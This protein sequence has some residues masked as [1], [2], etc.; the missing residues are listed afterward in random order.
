MRTYLLLALLLLAACG[1]ATSRPDQSPTG[2][3]TSVPVAPTNAASVAPTDAPPAAPAPTAADAPTAAPAAPGNEAAD[4]AALTFELEPVVEGFTRPV[5]VTAANDGSN[6]LF[7]TEQ[8]GAIWVVRDGQRLDEP[9]LDIRALVNAN[10]NEQGLLSIAFHPQYAENGRFFVGY[11][12]RNGDNTVAAYRVSDNPDRADHESGQVLLAVPDPAPNHNGGLVKFGPDGYLYIGMGDGGAAGDPWDNG[13]SLN[14]LLGKMLRI[15]VDNGEP[16]AIPDDNPF[17]NEANTQ[18][19]IWAWGLRNPWRF[20]F[21]RATGD[22]YIAD[23][24]QNEYEEVHFQPGTSAGGEN[25]GWNTV[26][27]DACFRAETCDTSGF[28][29]PVATYAHADQ[30]G[31]CSITGGYVYRGSAFPQMN[32]VYLYTDYCTGYLWAMQNTD[33]RWNN[34]SVAKFNINP[35]SFGEDEAGEL[36]LTDRDGGGLYRLVV[37]G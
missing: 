11:T 34:Q 7:V 2:R 27:G 37:Q 23:V 16:Y 33:G 6:R 13:Q 32:G 22:L 31:G 28:V 12:A 17:V 26:E 29:P 9:F 30:V 8:Y 21:D 15:D 19:E 20:S 3:A 1:S 5:H 18:P 36:Y 14:S 25:Y 24:G 35:S 4:L 10:G